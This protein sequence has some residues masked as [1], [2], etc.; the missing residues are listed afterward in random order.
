MDRIENDTIVYWIEGGILFSEFKKPTEM[1]LEVCK[2]LIEL[3]HSIS[4][5]EKQYWC[6]DFKMLKSYTKEG[7]DYA[8]VHGQDFLH[9]A[10]AIVNSHVTMFLY[11]IFVRIKKTKIPFKA[12]KNKED[13]VVWLNEVKAMNKAS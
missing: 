5:G 8:D 11:N 12:F 6:S 3:R 10:A 2:K 7:R 13:A 4:N 9:A 1:N